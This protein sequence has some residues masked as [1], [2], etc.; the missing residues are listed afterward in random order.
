MEFLLWDKQVP[1][2]K[3]T[4]SED[5]PA[6]FPYLVQGEN[7][8]AVIVCPGGG[9]G[10]RAD[11]EGEPIAKWL[12]SIGISAFVLRYRVAPYQYPAALLDLQRAI[13]TVRYHAKEWRINPA[14]VGTLGFSA[15]GHLVSTAG[16]HFHEV[17]ATLEDPIDEESSRPDLQ[18][19]CYSVITMKD[20]YTHQGS[21]TNLL[22]ERASIE[23]VEKLSNEEQVT[24]ETPP[25][26]LWHTA[27]DD[28]AVENSL[29]FAVALSK[30][31]VPFDLHI[32]EK[33]R[34]G[35]GLATEDEH[36]GTWTRQCEIW[37]KRNGF[38][39]SE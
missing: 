33:G 20:P 38:Q 30:N 23:L 34:H 8:S 11:H 37:L 35:L 10:M 12:N 21:R 28:V 31:K 18:I 15:G 32:Y 13:R 5:I 29:N 7:N 36:V 25:T 9:Y 16:T 22:G 1:L 26:F 39:R 14:K 19:L 6:L 2:S 27:D 4:S 3:G 24:N 17:E